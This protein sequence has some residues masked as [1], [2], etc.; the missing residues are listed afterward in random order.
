[1]I[2][3]GL[4]LRILF[5]TQSFPTSPNFRYKRQTGKDHIVIH[6][7]FSGDYPFKPPFVRVVE[8]VFVF[9][10]GHVT[11]GGAICMELLTNSGWKPFNGNGQ[12]LL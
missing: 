6:L 3:K 12:F 5:S 10:T 8:P 1:L 4:L 7:K 2:L 9:R 11:L